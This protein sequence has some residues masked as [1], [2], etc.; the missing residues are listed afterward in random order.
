MGADSTT[1]VA[2]AP[3]AM[4]SAS[5]RSTPIP[6]LG[7][8]TAAEFLRKHWQKT[9]LF[10]RGA[11]PAFADGK[12]L[13][14]PD[15]LAGLATIEEAKARL[16]LERRGRFHL[17]EG[18]FSDERFAKLPKKDWTLLVQGVNHFLP[19]AERLL[20][21]FCFI[22]HARLDDLMVSYAVRGG[23]V[24]PHLDS[25]DVFLVQGRGRR[26]WQISAQKDTALVEGAPLRILQAFFPEQEWET[27]AGDL[28][29]LPPRY[30]HHG[31]SLDDECMTYSIGFR[32][33]TEKE[34]IH[35]FLAWLPDRIDRSGTGGLYAD[36]DLESPVHPSEIGPD[37]IE[38]VAAML[39]RIKWN[40]D[41]IARFL[42]QYLSEP[43]PH[44]LHD[45]PRR[46]LSIEKFT[47]R[48]REK[49]IK[50]ALKSQML[51]H[52]RTF[53][54]NGEAYESA[55]AEHRLLLQLADDRRLPPGAKIGD[56]LAAQLHCWY[57]D[58]YL[59]VG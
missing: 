32:A 30:A 31:V 52:G 20:A 39:T 33:P 49:G 24:G 8:L 51:A 26:R 3:R 50:L 45:R 35:Q 27:T 47:D 58:G 19:E 53:F 56:K 43:K 1:E 40:R 10:V 22:P 42:G 41:D 55:P 18:P 11:F 48:V 5:P 54:L 57:R 4:R 7:G 38:K 46:P 37:M 34:L 29:Y 17:E 9:P 25:Y 28:L 36:P 14:D 12:G 6:F 23:S 15:D 21:E 16:V 44:V 59:E 13:L 2:Y